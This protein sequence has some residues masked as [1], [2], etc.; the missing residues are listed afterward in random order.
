[1]RIINEMTIDLAMAAIFAILFEI[2]VMGYVQKGHVIHC[3]KFQFNQS[4]G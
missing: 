2:W 4:I 1:M 3:A